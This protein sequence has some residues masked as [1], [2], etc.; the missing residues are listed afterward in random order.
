MKIGARHELPSD[1]VGDMRR[2]VVLAWVTIAFLLS[3]IV[4]LYFTLGASQAMKAAW[5]EDVVTLVSPIAFLVAA[6]LRD[7]RPDR[8]HPYGYHRVVAVSYLITAIAILGIGVF[9]I[10]DSAM[11]L[12]QVE[13]PTIGSKRIFGHT[14]WLG[15]LM[16]GA[17][18]YTIVPAVLLGRAKLPLAERLHDKALFA[19]AKMMKADWGTAAAGI[20]GILGIGIGLWWA[21][22]VAALVIA[23]DITH[24]GWANSRIAARDLMDGRPLLVDA[25][26][27]DPLPARVHTELTKLPWVDE[28]FVRLRNEGHVFFGEALV[29]PTNGEVTPAMI[30]EAVELTRGLDWR[31]HELAIV[32]VESVETPVDLP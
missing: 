29:V 25:S 1:R 13:I 32:P 20:L 26:A 27:A 17:L 16:I 23:A 7:R 19:D 9:V 10:Y 11:K 18:A 22:A 12:I 15:W 6:W 14:I 30:E 31:L 5:I 21:D 8:D 3:A 2:A 24:D 28:A 4:L